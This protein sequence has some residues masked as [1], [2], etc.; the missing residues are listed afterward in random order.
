M[1]RVKAVSCP[2]TTEVVSEAGKNVWLMFPT[3]MYMYLPIF[4]NPKYF[5]ASDW[6][7]ILL[8]MSAY[9]GESSK[10]PKSWTLEIQIL[11][12]DNKNE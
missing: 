8:F 12:L 7:S 11:K 5:I 4:P 1:Q 10:F 6:G 3:Y 2:Q 9:M